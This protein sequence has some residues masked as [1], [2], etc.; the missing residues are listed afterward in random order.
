MKLN[1]LKGTVKEI[2]DEPVTNARQILPATQN[3]NRLK[4]AVKEISGESKS[5]IAWVKK[6]Y[7]ESL[8]IRYNPIKAP[9]EKYSEEAKN[10]IK[11]TSDLGLNTTIAINV[12]R[13]QKPEI[14]FIS[15]EED[16][17]FGSIDCFYTRI[18]I[19]FEK[20]QLNGIDNI[21]IMRTPATEI[22]GINKPSFSALADMS[23]QNSKK[24]STS[25]TNNNVGAVN[26]FNDYLSLNNKITQNKNDVIDNTNNFVM[27][28]SALIKIK[29]VDRSVLEDRNFY[30]RN[31]ETNNIKLPL[32]VIKKSGINVLQGST[33]T[34]NSETVT[35]VNNSDGFFEV[36]K[37]E[38]RNFKLNGKF[39]EFEFFDP[40]VTYGNKYS[41][42]AKSVGVDGIS[43]L[44]SKIID[45]KILR[46]VSPSTPKIL[47]SIFNK[48]PRF[49]IICDDKFISHVEIFRN[50]KMKPDNVTSI[51]TD[52]AMVSTV[53]S[54]ILDSGFYHI[55]DIALSNDRSV[56]FV[57]RNVIHG[58][59][60]KYRFY[61]VD[62]FGV[63][64]QQ[65]FECTFNIPDDNTKN[66]IAPTVTAVNKNGNIELI[67]YSNDNRIKFY[68]IQVKNLS[69]NSKL[70]KN[71][72]T[73]DYF[74]IGNVSSSK[75]S[76]SRS[77]PRMNEFSSDAWSGVIR[78][79][80]DITVFLDR[81]VKFE[82]T[83]QYIVK[84][85]DL[86]GNES[87]YTTS[88]I[89]RSIKSSIVN[90]ATNLSSTILL[91]E[92]NIPSSVK[93]NWD[94]DV[95]SSLPSDVID[96]TDRNKIGFQLE[97]RKNNEYNWNFISFVTSTFYVDTD[98]EPNVF[99]DYRL[100]SMFSG[101]FVS[102]YTN[103]VRTKLF[104]ILQKPDNVKVNITDTSIR[105][106]SIILSWDDKQK[107]ADKWMIQRFVCNKI[108]GGKISY[109]DDSSTDVDW[110]ESYIV[111]R[112]SSRAHG[113]SFDFIDIDKKYLNSSNRIFIDNNIN[114]S[115]S[116][117]YRIK[118]IDTQG[119]ESAWSYVGI[120]I[121]D[122]LHDRKLMS[123][124]SD[125]DK[126]KL[127][128][129]RRKFDSF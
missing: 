70:Y 71:S 35:Q 78:N 122:S 51:N 16:I 128:N 28:E 105:P 4:D 82:S 25:Y 34:S 77:G 64:S 99:Y 33:V 38:S 106:V 50:G 85:I 47:Y 113:I 121:V 45:I 101:S 92:N 75:R 42:F 109:V 19:S 20:D 81:A 96:G 11:T 21:V 66:I 22:E 68:V 54:N 76:L 90:S 27:P 10:V 103:T 7:T 126:I 18:V 84:G 100:I 2:I 29:G 12:I 61:S 127:L 31:I 95:V 125:D 40:T 97:K 112:E 72:I 111:T 91:D 32:N 73:H 123:S 108:Y 119:N 62:C 5:D 48:L 53:K 117:F 79:T 65:P 44:R 14:D 89:I 114:L 23:T 17:Y 87:N 41:Y 24:S 6:S 115:N 104:Q 74:N 56:T 102:D 46:N 52:D 36:G 116:Y 94:T 39:A 30:N 3:L 129:D 124:L 80:G 86:H 93:F 13:P 43:S 59:T 9:V 98:V 120:K 15:I 110:E 49:S 1:F 118:A 67:I 8:P 58:N 55:G 107:Y 69:S 60:F 26:K 37:I 57:D 63:K 88:N 83:Y